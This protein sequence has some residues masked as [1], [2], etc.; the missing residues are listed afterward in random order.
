MSLLS[1]Q[2]ACLAFGHVALLDRA[3]M[4]IEPGER[5][6]LIGR[7]GTGK[8]SLL[9][10]LADLVELDDGR[11]VRRSGSSYAYLPQ[12]P[13]FDPAHTVAQAVAAALPE[14]AELLSRHRAVSSELAQIQD[15]GA[16]AGPTS[17]LP[18]LVEK[19]AALQ[20][21]LEA[22]EGW[23]IAH[24]IDSVLS[25]LGLDP[26]APVAALSGGTTKRVAL[27]RALVAEP[28]LLL[29]D[30]PT[31]HLDIDS[32]NWLEELLLSRRETTL[33]V[34][35]DR[36]L[37]DRVATRIVEL[38]RGVLR[39]YPGNFAAYQQRK[40]DELAQ[41]ASVNARFDKLL[42]QEEV[43]IRQGVEARRTRNEG[44]VRRLEDLRR[45]RD[46]R[47]NHLGLSRIEVDA[48]DQSGKQVAELIGV[49]KAWGQR[50][51]V[52]G[53][54]CVVSRGDRIGLIG[55]NGAG[56][57]TLIKLILGDLEPDEGKIR[58]GTQLTVAYFDQMR[59][60]LDDDATLIDTISPGSDWIEI[61]GKRTHVMSYLGRFLF[62]PERA[63][64]P[65][66]SLS[67]GERNRLLLARLFARPANLLV[68]DEPTNDLD[69]E[70]LEL[71]EELLA[72]YAGTVLLVSHDRAFLDAVVT[73]SIAFESD[74]RWLEYAGGYSEVQAA[75]GR[76]AITRGSSDVTGRNQPSVSETGPAD[77]S[78]VNRSSPSPRPP[79]SKLSYKEQRELDGL[80]ARIE[81]L[82]REQAELAARLADPDSYRD[83]AL[84]AKALAARH[85]QIETELSE[86]L[87]RWEALESRSPG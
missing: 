20:T 86:C 2:D 71:L 29:L 54:D 26:A 72:D 63:R 9:R 74:G 37:M 27:A 57:T 35:H 77:A 13:Q 76:V 33:L 60:Q 39:S 7:N 56:K 79:R 31:N 61:A 41:E 1:L 50:W 44:R 10:V 84:N 24:R 67:G 30:E 58:R 75:R 14:H 62:A 48:G 4:S 16:Q 11:V 85:A 47:R 68:L 66:K 69:I 34:T 15:H 73:Q 64:S 59:A 21:E 25:R 49:G 36:R 81:A 17:R 87:E 53:L 3:V 32:I 19:L 6:A 22:G 83:P 82:E 18:D 8:S 80:P 45:Q 42:A 23:S 28:D 52:R 43:W 38:D 12:E 70:T 65:V 55:P 78:G 46:M 51:V 5:I 40:V